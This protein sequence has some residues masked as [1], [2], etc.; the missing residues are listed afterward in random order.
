MIEPK[1]EFGKPYSDGSGIGLQVLGVRAW[2]RTVLMNG[3]PRPLKE[4]ADW[5]AEQDRLAAS[6]IN[7]TTTDAELAA[8]PVSTSARV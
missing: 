3:D 5:D 4:F 2:Y 8:E 6:E 7:S 1:S